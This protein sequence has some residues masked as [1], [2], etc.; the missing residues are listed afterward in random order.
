MQVVVLANNNSRVFISNSSCGQKFYYRIYL[1]N[2]MLVFLNLKF[3]IL[4]IN[5]TVFLKVFIAVPKGL[6]VFYNLFRNSFSSSCKG[7][8][9]KFKVFTGRYVFCKLVKLLVLV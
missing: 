7:Y 9:M 6:N 4:S 3:C 1:S 2:H 5:F 8:F